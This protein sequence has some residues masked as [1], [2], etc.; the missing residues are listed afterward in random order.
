MKK[1]KPVNKN[2]KNA[3][4]AARKRNTI[5][6][7]CGACGIIVIA[8]II[9][10]IASY[11]TDS[12]KTHKEALLGTWELTS[13]TSTDVYTIEFKKN[14]KY[15]YTRTFS[16]ESV[17]DRVEEGRYTILDGKVTLVS[18]NDQKTIMSYVYDSA[19]GKITYLSDFTKKN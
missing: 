9:I 19:T 3:K 16:S 4:S 14:N 2:S 13:E 8:T 1:N 10:I 7:I 18:E 15:V 5:I 11:S 17:A 6:G 12:D